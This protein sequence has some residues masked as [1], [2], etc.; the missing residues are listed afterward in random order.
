MEP[1]HPARSPVYDVPQVI[2]HRTV[3]RGA[4]VRGKKGN[5]ESAFMGDGEMS[6]KELERRCVETAYEDGV[7]QNEHTIQIFEGELP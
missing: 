2:G 5:V 6:C 4:F 7:P 1:R 3:A